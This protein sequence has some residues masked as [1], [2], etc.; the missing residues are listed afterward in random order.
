MDVDTGEI[1]L[2]CNKYAR[3]YSLYSYCHEAGISLK[4]FLKN[5][6][7]FQESRPN[8]VNA[9]EFP[10]WFIT[11]SDPRAAKAV[12]YIKS[13][14]LKIEGDMYYDTVQDGIVFPYYFD[15]TFVGA[16]VRFI[17]TK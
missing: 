14:G 10:S 8:E 3:G 17:E 1:W 12:E 6:F 13:R 7:E 2:W 5:D 9:V 11:L 16:Q 15:S 4:D